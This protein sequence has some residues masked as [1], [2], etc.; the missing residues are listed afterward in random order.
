MPRWLTN[1]W[2][3]WQRSHSALIHPSAGEHAILSMDM[4]PSDILALHQRNAHTPSRVFPLLPSH[5]T[6]SSFST[7]PDLP[8]NSRLVYL[9]ICLHHHPGVSTASQT[10]CALRGGPT[11]APAVP[12]LSPAQ[13]MADLS[14]HMLSPKHCQS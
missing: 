12:G 8:L 9:T 11:R 13:P 5:M 7:A 2:G 4:A 10:Q 3:P 14:F 6:S 1:S